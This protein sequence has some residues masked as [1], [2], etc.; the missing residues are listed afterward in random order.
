MPITKEDIEQAR[1]DARN[2]K[3][4]R[5]MEKEIY[6]EPLP[7]PKPSDK[8]EFKTLPGKPEKKKALGEDAMNYR[9][10]G[11]IKKYADGG[12]TQQPTYPF[13][14]N[15]P[16]AGGQNG[17]V[18]QTFNMQPQAT[19]GQVPVTTDQQTFKKGGRVKAS[20]MKSVKVASPKMGSASKR[21]DGIASRGKTRGRIV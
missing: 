21:A 18:N 4:Q 14:G 3:N 17:G 9:K 5:R 6:G 8:P 7:L 19:A 16:Q 10:G 11:K 12:M 2:E 13:Y 20:A 15:Q 1:R